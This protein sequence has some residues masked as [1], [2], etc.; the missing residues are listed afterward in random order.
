M[1]RRKAAALAVLLAGV[2][3]ISQQVRAQQAVRPDSTVDI[4]KAGMDSERLARITA[5][6]KEFV[7][8]GT[9]PG[10]VMLV[11]RHSVVA[12]LEAVGYQDLESK[13]PMRTDTIFAT[14]SMQ[15]SITAVGIMILLEEGR[16]TLNDPVENHLPEFRGQ[17]MV[18]RREG[19]QVVATK[20]PSRP[21][22]IR[23]LLAHTSGMR[24]EE[25][26][27]DGLPPRDK[28]L[29]EVV[30]IHSQQPLEFEP[31]TKFLYSNPGFRTLARIIEVASGQAYQDFLER[32]ILR[33]LG[34]RDTFYFVPP[35]KDGR[36]ASAYTLENGHLTKIALLGQ[37]GIKIDPFSAPAPLF[38]RGTKFVSG[39]GGWFSTATDMFAFYQ[40]MLNGGTYNGR[41]ILSRASVGLMTQMHAHS[42]PDFGYGLGWAVFGALAVPP[43]TLESAGTYWHGGYLGTHGW[44]DPEK[45]LVGIFMM[46]RRPGSGPERSAFIA[47]A[48]AAI[49]DDEKSKPRKNDAGMDPERLAR[50]PARM[51]EFVE[52][53]TLAGAVMLVAR[54]G[55]VALLEAVGYQDLESKKPMRTD[56]IFRIHSMTK[57]VTAAGIMILLE[58]G[59]LLL[60]DRIETYLPEFRG[61]MVIDRK[62]GD[63]VL[64]TKKPSRPITIRDLLTHTSGMQGGNHF[65]GNKTLAETVAIHARQPLEFEPGTK[66]LYSS[67]GFRTLGRIIAVV[68]GQS[69]E[70]FLE[71]RIFRPLGMK[72]TLFVPPPEKYDRIGP[73][74][75]LENGKLTK[76]N[77]DPYRRGLILISS[78]GGLFSTAADMFA[79][80]QMMLNGGT[81][82]GARILSQLS[83]ETMT[84]VHTG[85]LQ[86]SDPGFGWGL[87]WAVH[88]KPGARGLLLS[89][90][91][92]S[93]G[94][95]GVALGSVD[96]K[97][98]LVGLFLSS[99]EMSDPLAVSQP[100]VIF[101]N[102]VTAAIVD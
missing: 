57:P 76:S 70:N 28:T 79:F 77:V 74:Y 56:N 13:K 59:R 91:A 73:R 19:G 15:K 12:Y 67:P 88:K 43:M 1:A 20:K 85:D 94:G 52:Q 17:V 65:L 25:P 34:M 5:R 99:T 36:I 35:E 27:R 55:Q 29:A 9:I 71:Q 81:Y 61:Q 93:H 38:R 80:Y 82:K 7:E 90:G 22:T 83:V 45:D 47:M 89:T 3:L 14:R 2:G 87:G 54:H 75:V 16:L 58:E 50:I 68:S 63:K 86:T 62:E 46:H 33:P 31:G 84:A 21:I 60:S 8:K 4:S 48:A 39:A 37:P 92:Y 23:D 102:M 95:G 69:L 41:R 66:F 6:M 42:R 101:M 11:A 18:D 44:V 40:M 53:G 78:A 51:K 26:E 64:A 72:D 24:E 30:R 32:R 97:K 10:A 98:E 100:R 96:P 49:V